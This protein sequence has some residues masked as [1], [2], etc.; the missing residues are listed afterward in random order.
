MARPKGRKVPKPSTSMEIAIDSPLSE[1]LQSGSKSQ[2]VL[3]MLRVPTAKK[4][5]TIGDLCTIVDLQP[6][7]MKASV[8]GPL[9]HAQVVD[10]EEDPD[11][12]LLYFLKKSF[13][14]YIE[15]DPGIMV[16]KEYST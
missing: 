16:S 9:V 7:H 13:R 3:A 2:A 5:F 12:G 10:T 6:G 8:L 14:E 4:G 15:G 1:V 11:R